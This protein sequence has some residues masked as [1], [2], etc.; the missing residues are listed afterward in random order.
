MAADHAIE[1]AQHALLLALLL[2]AP[3]L[4]VSLVTSL[5][6]G[7]LQTVTQLHDQ[8]LSFVPRLLAV[9]FVALLTLPWGLSLLVEY[10]SELFQN[11]PA[12]ISLN[13][14]PEQEWNPEGR[15]LHR[16]GRSV[17]V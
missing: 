8:S 15:P 14:R 6:T 1:L 17:H 9:V 16:L 10:S 5:I 7:V 4:A 12:S 2:V 3:I 13:D 11:I